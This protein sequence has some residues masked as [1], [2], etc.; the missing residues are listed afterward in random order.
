MRS[1]KLIFALML[2][3]SSF[4]RAHEVRPA[5]FS[6]TQINDSTFQVVWK[7]PAMGN[8]IPKI[9]PILPDNWIINNEKANLLPGNLRQTYLLQ[10]EGQLGGNKIY[11]E[12][13]EKTLID[14]LVSINL[15][16]GAKY[17]LM[18]RP[19]NP[20]YMIPLVPKTWDVIKTY[21]ILG[22]EHIL[23][24]IDHLLFVLALLLITKGFKRL[25][26]T[27]TAFTIAHSI[28]LSLATLGI[29]GLPGP[30]VEAIIALSIV[31]LAVELI[32]YY[33]GIEGYTVRYPWIVA[34]VF[35]LLHGFGFAGALAQVGLPQT[36]IP[37]ALLF[38]N[39][40]VEFGQLIFVIAILGLFW[41]VNKLGPSWPAWFK[42]VPPY[43]IG[44][45]A[46]FWLIERFLGF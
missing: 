35:G 21:I 4:V 31:F 44:S 32:H 13:L 6:M 38:F 28:T 3:I 20:T 1:I 23:S 22:I 9:Y 42:W 37:T 30:P 40:G 17:S 29:I 12:G 36:E 11:F 45:L 33:R 10:I 19:S 26:K 7:L 14:I 15:L 25:V 8:A 27:I 34:F 39:V 41:V 18:V 24:G 43:A 16:D 5:F 2:F 46:S